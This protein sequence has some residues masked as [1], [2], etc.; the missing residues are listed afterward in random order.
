MSNDRN[1]SI[2]VS[3]LTAAIMVYVIAPVAIIVLYAFSPTAYFSLPPTG[4]TLKWFHSFIE[5]DR[6]RQALLDLTTI[7]LIA[8]PVARTGRAANCSGGGA[9]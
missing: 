9:L 5:N 3:L 7:S 4:A 2:S 6:F 1:Y 8:T